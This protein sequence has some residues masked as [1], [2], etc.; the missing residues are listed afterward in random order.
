MKQLQ[1]FVIQYIMKHAFQR[2]KVIWTRFYY[3]WPNKKFL[4]TLPRNT[5]RK[6]MQMKYII[7]NVLHLHITLGTEASTSSK[8]TDSSICHFVHRFET[9]LHVTQQLLRRT[10][11]TFIILWVTIQDG[12]FSNFCKEPKH[13]ENRHCNMNSYCSANTVLDMFLVRTCNSRFVI[14]K[15]TINQSY[16]TTSYSESMQNLIYAS[17]CALCEYDKFIQLWHKQMK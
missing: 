14:Q 4:R 3:I 16:S 6:D 12:N 2:S 15:Y 10:F 5:L 17:A 13:K 11:T 7:Q 1:N 8:P 9:L